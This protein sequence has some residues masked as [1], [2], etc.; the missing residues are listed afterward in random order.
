MPSFIVDIPSP[1]TLQ[2]NSSS[3][4]VVQVQLSFALDFGDAEAFNVNGTSDVVGSA[5]VAAVDYVYDYESIRFVAAPSRRRLL[6]EE[7]ARRVDISADARVSSSFTKEEATRAVASSAKS[8]VSSGALGMAMVVEADTIGFDAIPDEVL[9]DSVLVNESLDLIS[10]TVNLTVITTRSPSSEPSF[11]PSTVPTHAPTGESTMSPSEKPQAASS[12]NSKKKKGRKGFSLLTYMVGV[13]I[14]LVLIGIIV[15]ICLQLATASTKQTV[16]ISTTAPRAGSLEKWPEDHP[17]NQKNVEGDFEL[18]PQQDPSSFED[19][20]EGETTSPFVPSRELSQDE[21][22]FMLVLEDMAQPHLDVMDESSDIE[23]D[24]QVTSGT[25]DRHLNDYE[26]EQ[27]LSD[28]DAPQ[29]PEEWN[30]DVAS[31]LLFKLANVRHEQPEGFAT[32][33]NISATLRDRSDLV[34]MLGLESVKERGELDALVFSAKG[35]AEGHLS[36]HQFLQALAHSRLDEKARR[37]SFA[38]SPIPALSPEYSTPTQPRY[39]RGQQK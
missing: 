17:T 38:A 16:H 24:I 18:T 34:V 35:D 4:E 19:E 23:N 7:T 31:I 13:L 39:A 6:L 33:R 21:E 27:M 14:I 8:A 10:N 25:P 2:P 9:V 36:R 11:V 28:V 20:E 37:D 32:R 12:T 5:F 26:W 1:T 3:Q 15:I 29:A 22:G 30:E